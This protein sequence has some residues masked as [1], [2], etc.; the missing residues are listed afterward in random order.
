MKE[1]HEAVEGSTGN[2]QVYNPLDSEELVVNDYLPPPEENEEL[3][4]LE[5]AYLAALPTEVNHINKQINEPQT[6]K[7]V[8]DSNSIEKP[9]VQPYVTMGTMIEDDF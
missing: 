8:A 6:K 3:P 5:H 9:A 4:P 1:L 7:T 2:K